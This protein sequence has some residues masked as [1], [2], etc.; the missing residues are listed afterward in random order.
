MP[1]TNIKI[2]KPHI[3]L[4]ISNSRIIHDIISYK[5]LFYIL[6]LT[7]NKKIKNFANFVLT[8][9]QASV[10]QKE[11]RNSNQIYLHAPFYFTFSIIGE[12]VGAKLSKKQVET[13][14][15]LRLSLIHI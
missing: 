14:G 5:H 7:R 6:F 12:F 13:Q 8:K 4:M 9:F 10:N 1:N 3:A 15:E 2:T 11:G